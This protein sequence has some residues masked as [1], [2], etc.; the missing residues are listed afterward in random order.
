MSSYAAYGI[1]LAMH[2]L[3]YVFR[4][5][6]VPYQLTATFQR[7]RWRTLAAAH[8]L[9]ATGTPGEF[10]GM[11]GGVTIVLGTHFA[12]AKQLLLDLR[13][14]GLMDPS[15]TSNALCTQPRFARWRH[16]VVDG[17]LRVHVPFRGN[18]LEGGDVDA[19]LA[20]VRTVSRYQGS[21]YRG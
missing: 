1:W 13:A 7:S 16:E 14:L 19:W 15:A 18:S 20:A 4:R 10:T 8:G 12:P 6:L 2:V 9:V 5:R 11:W 21:V 17:E 3:A